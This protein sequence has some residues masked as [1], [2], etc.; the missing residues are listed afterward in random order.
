MMYALKCP[1]CQDMELEKL[2]MKNM[3]KCKWCDKEFHISELETEEIKIEIEV[4]NN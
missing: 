2:E 4:I 1:R 3:F